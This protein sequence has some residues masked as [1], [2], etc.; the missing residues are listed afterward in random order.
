MPTKAL[1]QAITT[2]INRKSDTKLVID[3]PKNFNTGVTLEAYQSFTG[4]ITSTNEIYGLIPGISQGNNDWQRDGNDIQPLSLTT[5]VKLNIVSR[6]SSSAS[7]YADVFFLTCKAVKDYH[8]TS[9]ILTGALMNV[10]DGTNAPY[11]GTSF[12]AMYPINK[13]LFTVLKH[14]RIKLQKSSENPNQLWSSGEVP[15]TSPMPYS[16]EFS[17]KLPLPSKFLYRD[18]TQAYPTNYFPFMCVGF[19]ATDQNGDTSLL[20]APL[21]VQAQSHLYFKDL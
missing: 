17:V 5:K 1:T 20:S 16:T 8:L 9:S 19:H 2:V 14:K 3:A 12:T 18:S 21:R 15:S 11:D 7:I 6:M 10:G 4:G 13:S